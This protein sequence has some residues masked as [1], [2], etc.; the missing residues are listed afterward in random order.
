MLPLPY[1]VLV[2]GLHVGHVEVACEQEVFS[3]PITATKIWVAG[4]GTVAT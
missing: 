1:H 2:Q 4:T 3:G